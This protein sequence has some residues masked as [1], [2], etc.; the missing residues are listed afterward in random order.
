[1]S[2]GMAVRDHDTFCISC[3]TA[4][5]YALARP[6]LRQMLGQLS[7]S[8][9]EQKIIDDVT[10]RVRLWEDVQPYYPFQ[11]S[12]SRGTEAVLNTL[13]L[14]SRDARQG[15]L[16]VDSRTAFE[17]MWA[18][19]KGTGPEKGAWP[20]IMFDNE[21]WEAKDSVF[22]GASLA[23]IAVG[24]APENYRSTPEI[25]DQLNSLVDYLRREYPKQTL[26]NQT[27]LLW[28]SAKLPGLLPPGEQQA[29]LSA[30]A[31]QQHADGG[32]CLADLVGK[33]KRR[34]GTPQVRR[35]DG[36]A[37]GLITFTLEEMGI[38][39]R[40]REVEEGLSWLVRHQSLWYG[41][42]SAYSLNR[43]QL[44]PFSNRAQ[45]MDDAATAYAVLALTKTDRAP[46]SASEESNAGRYS[47]PQN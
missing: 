41:N 9:D 46:S 29:I 12:N 32:W 20:W 31:S 16:G 37:T 5:P 1:M 40:N 33:W 3:H 21:P 44:S 7:P 14:A 26:A 17:E 11:A 45:F 15:R 24:I 6:V 13:I 25:Q 23:A 28:A 43:W 38:P 4:L 8:I 47:R 36:Y 30:I 39:R 2:W 18:T 34:D 42:W 35:S 27:V 22:Y 10:K 19:Q